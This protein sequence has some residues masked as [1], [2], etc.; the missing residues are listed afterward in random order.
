MPEFLEITP[1]K[2]IHSPFHLI[3]SVWQL[4]AAEKNGQVNAMTASWGGLGVMW[5][6]NVAYTVVRPQ[7]YTK[8]FMDASDTFSISFFGDCYRDMLH[9]MGTTSGRDADKVVEAGLTVL[10]D[11][12]T[13]YFEEATAVI[14][15]RKMYAQEMHENCFIEKEK[16]DKWYPNKDFHMLYISEIEKILMKEE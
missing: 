5:G 8:E 1:D 7:R 9:Y 4:I 3:G 15:C 11:G 10:H 13:S 14:I 12:Q 16:A 2:F 6:K